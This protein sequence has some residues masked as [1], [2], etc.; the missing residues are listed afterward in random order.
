MKKEIYG[1][2]YMVKNLVNG[3]M[4]FGI[5]EDNFDTRYGG[6]I[7]KHTHND[8]LK[9]SI[10]KYGIENFEINEKF[11]VAYTEDEMW[12][13]EDL[14]ICIYNTLDPR[15]GYNKRRSG[16]KRK[17][18]GKFSEEA[19]K[20][21]SDSKKGKTFS[22]ETR[23]LWSEQK[24]GEGNPNY[25]KHWDDEHKKKISD[26]VSKATTGE[27]NPMYGKKHTDK[28]KRKISEKAKGRKASNE[29]KVKMS[30]KRQG[31]DN[32][33]SKK[34]I[35]LETNEIFNTIGEAKQWCGASSI[36][37]CCLG[38]ISYSGKHPTTREKLHWKY[39][40]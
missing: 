18:C 36:G 9:R 37:Q 14:Y 27:K 34:V 38:K 30:K 21:M 25:G 6:D 11:D 22:E 4:Y 29:T 3:K 32:P 15:Y 23:Q 16:S 13:L 8:H 35:C 2:I 19:K 28:A 40:D 5:T 7:A 20:K 1:Y 17:G 31:M 39:V 10:K 33:N 24:K 26:S 12:D